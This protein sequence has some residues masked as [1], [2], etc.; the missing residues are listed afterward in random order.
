MDGSLWKM[1][2]ELRTEPECFWK[3][4]G[5]A[6]TGSPVIVAHC[7]GSVRN[8][9]IVHKAASVKALWIKV[10]T[11]EQRALVFK[12]DEGPYLFYLMFLPQIR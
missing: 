10:V 3:A 7:D 5:K 2:L 6:A 4:L 8:T 11:R 9:D 12:R 1:A